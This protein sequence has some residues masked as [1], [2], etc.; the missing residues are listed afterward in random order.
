MKSLRSVN[1][2]LTR[3]LRCLFT[4]DLSRRKSP[5]TPTC[6]AAARLVDIAR[7]VAA[8]RTAEQLAPARPEQLGA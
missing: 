2:L 1:L 7:A 3:S 4:C 8:R 6:S 5:A